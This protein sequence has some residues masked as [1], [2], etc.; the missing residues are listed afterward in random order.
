M[1][2][3]VG[4]KRRRGVDC[5]REFGCGGGG[6]GDDEGVRVGGLSSEGKP[7]SGSH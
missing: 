5:V 7:E 3:G 6:G 1:K 2:G 4:R